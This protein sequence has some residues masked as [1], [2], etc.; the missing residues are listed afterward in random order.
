MLSVAIS[1][2][3]VVV[4]EG[5]VAPIESGGNLRRDPDNGMAQLSDRGASSSPRTEL[6]SILRVSE[7][8]SMQ[9]F[10]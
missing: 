4:A 8:R 6:V 2:P 5:R 9:M 10:T 3:G 7:G 1:R